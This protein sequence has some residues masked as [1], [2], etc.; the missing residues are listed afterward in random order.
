M[1]WWWETEHAG[2]RLGFTSR[3]QGNLALHVGEGNDAAANRAR[4][5]ARLGLA[6]GQL[7]FLNQ[8]H[9]AEVVDASE[10]DPATVHTETVHTGDAWISPD[11]SHPLAI[12]VAD[13]L[14]V[15]LTAQRADGTPLTAAAHAG[16]PG[17]I[18]GILEN[19]VA[20]LRRYSAVEITAWIGPGACGDCYEVPQKMHDELTGD[21]PALSSTTRW[22]TPALDLRAQAAV[23]LQAAGVAVVDVPG[24]TIEA[25][26]LFSHRRS[27]RTGEPE[28]R[29]AGIITPLG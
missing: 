27:Q 10:A 8:V 16:R 13:C 1:A 28:G 21:R 20:Q 17:L 2:F 24:C 23:V 22:G 25:P 15:L 6:T 26:Q 14:P 18:A 9:S 29:L 5:A 4:L 11:G 3:A 7:R 12:M 19:T